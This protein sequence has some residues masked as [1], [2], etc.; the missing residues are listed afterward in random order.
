MRVAPCAS[1]RPNR[2]LNSFFTRV[3]NLCNT[4]CSASSVG[5]VCLQAQ[6]FPAGDGPGRSNTGCQRCLRTRRCSAWCMRQRCVGASS[7]IT[8]TSSRISGS[9]I[10]T[11]GAGGAFIITPACASPPT[12]SC[13][14]NGYNTT[15][16]SWV[17]KTPLNAKSLPYP[18]TTNFAEAHRIQ[19][20][21]PVLDH[22]LANADWILA[23]TKSPAMS[24]PARRSAL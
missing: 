13:S 2:R 5:L 23:G 17:E 21:R 3:M 4:A 20:V 10:A 6:L 14:P 24:M 7:L 16:R 19:R 12:A 11:A 8:K 1:T 22:E 18:F 9:V 15:T